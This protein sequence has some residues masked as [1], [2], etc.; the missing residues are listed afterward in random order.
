MEVGSTD[1]E[2]LDNCLIGLPRNPSSMF[3]IQEAFL[4]EGIPDISLIYLGNF[5]MLLKFSYAELKS[6]YME[7]NYPWL[8]QWFSTLYEWS[9]REAN[10]SRTV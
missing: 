10:L 8:C 9:F 7:N 2:W 5:K 6:R 1:T 3:Q 4:S